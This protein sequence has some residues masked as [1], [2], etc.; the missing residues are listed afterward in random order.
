M[1]NF[2]GY[3]RNFESVLRGLLEAGHD[4]HIALEREDKM[5]GAAWAEALRAEQPRLSWSL[6]PGL[7]FDP[8]Y[9]AMREIRLA[10]DYVQALRPE[11]QAAPE[12]VARAEARASPR[13]V[14]LMQRPGMRGPRVR[15]LIVSGLNALEARIPSSAELD[16]YL[17]ALDPDIVLLTPHL[18]PGSQHTWSLR[19][20]EALG[21]PTVLCVASWDNLS[22]KQLIQ[23]RPDAVTV[24]NDLQKREAVELHGLPPESVVVTGAQLYDQW[25][26]WAARPR[27]EFCARVGLPEARPYLLY[28]AGALFPAKITEPEF[29]LRWIR[30]L[31][32]SDQTAV[33]EAAILIRPHPKRMHEWDGIDLSQ[34]E[35][36]A[37]WPT[38]AGR[39]PVDEES[40]AD[41]YDSIYHSA[42]VVGVNTSAMIEAGIVGR[43][44]YTLLVPEFSGS[45]QGT[46]HFR[47]LTDVAGGLLTVARDLEE[48]VE[49]LA[50][51]FDDPDVQG[52]HR[53]FIEAFIRPQGIGVSS[54][55]GF[56][57]TI[58][59]V[60][61]GPR[62]APVRRREA[63]PILRWPLRVLINWQFIVLAREYARKKGVP[64]KAVWGSLGGLSAIR[65]PRRALVGI[66]EAQRGAEAYR[67][68]GPRT[69]AKR[70]AEAGQRI[71][72]EIAA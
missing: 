9:F 69:R 1:M 10:R 2:A 56:V 15:R 3:F 14:R 71:E 59:R 61:R 23:S 19:S 12:L 24:W 25:F 35:D 57:A 67:R 51:A 46:F 41:L 72:Q 52:R 50:E 4:V 45:Q 5:G 16:R 60:A 54:T 7:K 47:Y 13:I 37:L 20:A 6:T 30:S 8:W 18:M 65:H 21:V 38:G 68:S 64:V 22:S 63:P 36:V 34:F 42:A 27:K 48:H 32:A 49:Q 70:N 55:P 28:V 44:V 58:E 11:F 66:L 40:K 43:R 33:R 53:D 62:R 29:V 26:E 39:M 17:E 31:R